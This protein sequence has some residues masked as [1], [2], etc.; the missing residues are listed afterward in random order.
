MI[1][2]LPCAFRGLKSKARCQQVFDPS[3]KTLGEDP[4]LTFS[5]LLVVVNNPWGS[6]GYSSIIL[7]SVCI[8]IS[9]CPL[10]VCVCVYLCF[11]L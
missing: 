1:D 9:T 2:L 6:M 7:I 3:L 8:H 5:Q 4:F 10:R 11:L